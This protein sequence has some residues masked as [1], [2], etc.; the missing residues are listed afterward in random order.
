[1]KPCDK[2]TLTQKCLLAQKNVDSFGVK[3]PKQ[4]IA[5]LCART[6]KKQESVSLQ[7]RIQIFIF[8]GVWAGLFLFPDQNIKPIIIIL[9]G[10]KSFFIVTKIEDIV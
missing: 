3:T 2:A 9:W 8:A 1:M 4:I 10:R 7:V 5:P 6:Y